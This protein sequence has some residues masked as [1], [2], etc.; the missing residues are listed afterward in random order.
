MCL[1]SNPFWP[2]HISPCER[3]DEPW[4]CKH[5]PSILPPLLCS[6][7]AYC[8]VLIR[9]QIWRRARITFSVQERAVARNGSCSSWSWDDRGFELRSERSAHYSANG[10]LLT[11]RSALKRKLV[12]ITVLLNYEKIWIYKH[13]VGEDLQYTVF[14]FQDI[15]PFKHTRKHKFNICWHQTAKT[16]QHRK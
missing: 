14:A 2:G 1:L 11:C 16:H 3:R 9:G 13:F 6:C 5:I 8:E 4:C 12:K 15:K 10:Q 7:W